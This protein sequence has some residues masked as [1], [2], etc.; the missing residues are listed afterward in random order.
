MEE[1]EGLSP[2]ISTRI[3]MKRNNKHNVRESIG[4]IGVVI[5]IASYG[6][7]ATGI[8]DNDSILYHSLVFVGA[9]GVAS[10]SYKK[11]DLQPAVLNAIFAILALIALFRLLLA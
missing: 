4:W 1:V 3:Y 2:S 10:V 5:I 7:L 8:V 9:L 6:L 11:H